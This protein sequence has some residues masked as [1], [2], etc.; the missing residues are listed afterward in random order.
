MEPE[1]HDRGAPCEPR[2]TFPGPITSHLVV[3]DGWSVP[4]LEANFRGEEGVQLLLDGRI[5]IDLG[6]NEAERLIP[7][8]ADAIAVALGYGAHPRGDGPELPPKL[9]HRAPRRVVQVEMLPG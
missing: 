4:F 8:L 5:G 1:R 7:F 9:P 2:V 6:T 3:V